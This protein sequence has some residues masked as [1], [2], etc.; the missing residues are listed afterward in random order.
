MNRPR[1]TWSMAAKLAIGIV[2]TGL[3]F[4]VDRS[5]Y[6]PLRAIL[7]WEQSGEVRELF[8]A[9]KAFASGIGTALIAV[10]I[11][12][13]DRN[14]R[15]RAIAFLVVVSCSSLLGL[16]IK[17]VAGRERPSHLDQTPGQER[18]AFN[19][20]SH[21]LREAPFRSFPSGHTLTAF[22]SATC[23]SAF[24]PTAHV[25]FY[26]VATA[27]GLNRIVKHQH[28]PSDVLFGALVGHAWA[29]WMLSW[30]RIRRWAGKPAIDSGRDP[31]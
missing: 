17:V 22:A 18:I 9:A 27:T 16:G 23:L 25:A 15:R 11:A 6:E 8:T 4:A 14:H 30:R 28:F 31:T 10:V 20:P 21:G 5:V 1:S 13:L 19:G 29:S 3:A 12:V 26:T 7:F 2:V 24:Y